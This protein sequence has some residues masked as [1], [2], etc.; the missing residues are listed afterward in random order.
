MLNANESFMSNK[1]VTFDTTATNIGTSAETF[2][3]SQKPC[4]LQMFESLT[5]TDKLQAFKSIM[6]VGILY[7]YQQFIC[8][9][10]YFPFLELFR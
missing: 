3:L 2:C 1:S 6:E 5:E 10:F 7:L 8:V 4:T 9:N